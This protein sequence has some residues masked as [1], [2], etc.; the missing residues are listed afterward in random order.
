MHIIRRWG[1]GLLFAP[2]V[3]IA[4]GATAQVARDVLIQAAFEDRSRD[5]ALA[6]VDRVRTAALASITRSPG[7]QEAALIAALAQ[8]YRAKLTGSRQEAMTAKKDL[9]ALTRRFPN[10][11][12]ARLSLGAWHLGIIKSA[13]RM[14]GRLVGAQRGTGV[15]SIEQ[16]VRAG[17]D[18]AMFSGLAGMMLVDVDPSN[19]RGRALVEQ[20]TR[21]SAPTRLDKIVQRNAGQVATAFGRND[22]KLARALAQRLLPFGWYQAK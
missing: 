1:L 5:V 17:G 6:R 3:L 13:G 14:V 12:E 20:A 8:G 10:N 2:A 15:A 18:R 4:S 9:D 16:A 11:P 7:D 22:P 21:A 19:P